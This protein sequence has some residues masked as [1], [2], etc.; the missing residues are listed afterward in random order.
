[1]DFPS[2][3]PRSWLGDESF[4]TAPP[5]S[6]GLTGAAFEYHGSDCDRA[7]H[8]HLDDE[9]LALVEDAIGS[10]VCLRGS[11]R[12]DAGATLSCL[13][14]LIAEAQS[15]LPDTVADARDEAYTWAEIATRLATTASTVR[16]RYGGY[17]RWVAGLAVGGD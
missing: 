14:S 8:P 3:L 9:T 6:C 11:V 13:A 10:L 5:C 17:T 16:R 4:P 15:R 12:G 7:A 1:M 2:C